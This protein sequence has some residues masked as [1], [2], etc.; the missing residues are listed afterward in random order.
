MSSNFCSPSLRLI[1]LQI[2]IFRFSAITESC[3]K[4]ISDKS[5]LEIKSKLGDFFLKIG[6]RN[7]SAINLSISCPPKSLYR[8]IALLLIAIPVSLRKSTLSIERS[9]VPP[10]KSITKIF[11]FRTSLAQFCFSRFSSLLKYPKK[12]ALGS[13]SSIFSE[14]FILAISAA[15]ITSIL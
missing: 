8:E 6:K 9:K 10:P 4:I 2:P 11:L 14:A 15:L 13:S 5:A 3:G 1:L 12:A 7:S